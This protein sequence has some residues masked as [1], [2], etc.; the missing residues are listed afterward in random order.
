MRRSEWR[1][2][3]NSQVQPGSGSCTLQAGK[4]EAR[5]RK[6]PALTEHGHGGRVLPEQPP[7]VMRHHR[8]AGGCVLDGEQVAQAPRVLQR[9]ASWAN[10]TLA[11]RDGSWLEDRGGQVYRETDGRTPLGTTTLAIAHLVHHAPVPCPVGV[12]DDRGPVYEAEG[13]AVALAG[14]PKQHTPEDDGLVVS[15]Q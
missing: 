11:G 6:Y 7:R 12:D 3:Q 13:E 1:D 4:V 8:D 9:G 15:S 14:V 5:G 2:Q 10:L